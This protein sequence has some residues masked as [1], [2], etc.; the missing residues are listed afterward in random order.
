[1]GR[2]FAC[3]NLS[4]KSLL[5]FRQV[6]G[7]FV[8]S[9]NVERDAGAGA[10]DGYLP[11]GRSMD[12]VRRFAQSIS[13]GGRALSIT[14]PYGSGKSSLAVF[15]D[16]LVRPVGDV[17]R[18][19][20]EEVCAITD[21]ETLVLL[22]QGRQTMGGD[23]TGFIRALVTAER[24]AVTLTVL[25]A[26]HRGA[27]QFQ[28]SGELKSVRRR[29]L[30]MIQDAID[31]FGDTAAAR[32]TAQTIR[33]ILG[34]LERMAP[35]LLLIDEFGKNL[36][37]YADDPAA[38][39]LYVL[40][41]MAEWSGGPKGVPLVLVTVQHLAFSDYLSGAP[42]AQRRELAKIQ[43][44]FED[45]S[46]VE[47]AHQMRSLIAAAWEPATTPVFTTALES[48]ASAHNRLCSEV[49]LTE[50]LGGESSLAGCW[51]LHPVSQLVLPELCCRYG[52][53]ERT[54]F[55]FLAGGEPASVST[56]LR[57]HRWDGEAPL[58]SIGVDR[59]YDYFIESAG[60]LVAVSQTA[61]RWLEIEMM[62]RDTV[63]LDD[64]ER[65]ALKTVGVL[66][67]VS[68]GGGLRASRATATY[69]L[70]TSLDGDALDQASRVLDSL[71]ARGLLIFRDFADEYRLWRGSDFDLKSAID[72]AHRRL[73]TASPSAL[74]NRVRP[75]GPIVAGSHS[76]RTHTLRAFARSWIDNSTR[77]VSPPSNM[78]PLDGLLLYSLG[79]EINL[80]TVA[81]SQM[82]SKPIVVALPSTAQDIV[83]IA[84]ELAALQEVLVS[85]D[86]LETDWVVRRELGER[87]AEADHRLDT[88][89]EAV[90]S[91]T[92]PVTWARLSARNGYEQLPTTGRRA[93][94]VI[95]A[96][97]DEIYE[98]APYVRNEM[99]NR[100]EL[101]SQ[102]AKGRRELLE[103]MVTRGS[104]PLL[105]IAGY[106]PNRAMYA[107]ALSAPGIHRQEGQI[108]GFYPPLP[109]STFE[110]AW[111]AL[112]DGFRKAK[113]HRVG[114]DELIKRLCAPPIGMRVGAA[115]VLLT[116]GLVA[117]ADEMAIYEHG[118][119]RP[120]FSP[121]LS[122]RMVRNPVHFE[123]KH[124]AAK[125][126]V[127]AHVIATLLDAL[128][129]QAGLPQQRNGSVLAVLG[130]LVNEVVLRLPEFTRRTARLSAAALA[131]RNALVSATEPDEL[132]FACL[133]ECFGFDIV[134][135][136]APKDEWD[137]Y[138]LWIDPLREAV[139]EM[140]TCYVG[141]LNEMEQAI[142]EAT[143]A[144]PDD[145]RTQLS[146]R[147]SSL[148]SELI[149][150][151]LRAFVTSLVADLDRDEWLAYVCS[152]VG[153]RPPEN[154]S[155]D[156][157]AR[158][159]LLIHELG[160]SFRRVEALHYDRKAIRS[161]PSNV[162]RITFSLPGG[163]E[164]ARL[165][166]YDQPQEEA[167]RTLF[168]ELIERA[169]NV[170][171]SSNRARDVL[172]AMLAGPRSSAQQGSADPYP[173]TDLPRAS[174]TNPE[175]RGAEGG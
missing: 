116:A 40:Q 17:T 68:A 83:A 13:A 132:I 93:S 16:A 144:A 148:Q 35:I 28:A 1:M 52:Q 47:S 51:P 21:P 67:L 42:E 82:D 15:L 57:G 63:G 157:R 134:P 121:D 105:G 61:S 99:L 3:D 46:F 29:S 127:R 14:G 112:L 107:A 168:D 5:E 143:G 153:K 158:C 159:L 165:L 69:A 48:W 24:E 166:W 136:S 49:G 129:V 131:V 75:L 80:P 18:V 102:G 164:Q 119:Y 175:R 169:A 151:R 133:P 122:E 72:A 30:V 45:I 170:L 53:N 160:D 174:S 120:V 95:S 9:I 104:E 78:D 59:L 110:P 125:S 44:R 108:W 19:R 147:A 149:E 141:L 109:G 23:E 6:R 135:T 140:T 86:R 85:E 90:L 113:V 152:T 167:V 173:Q 37:S 4:M 146:G 142:I 94:S 64:L 71:E 41:Q 11:T 92:V 66:N 138:C 100:T 60:A 128:G 50:V 161:K 106:G 77:A 58:P 12:V 70:S 114:V 38:G 26:L 137:R 7:R 36:E 115:A 171:G 79:S 118:T 91:S 20:A 145:Y 126:G 130:H 32:P 10:I 96:I 62:V 27:H 81:T 33:Q 89:F 55:S 155:D 54:L 162:V 84:T 43:G 154:W 123:V 2:P 98:L 88:A 150:L 76:Q 139:N 73:Q 74:L 97:A 111:E 56:F 103:A 163:E 65:K 34:L 87:I 172:L 22:N 25:R 124:F 101:S 117:H 156:D 39:D 31:R 8:R